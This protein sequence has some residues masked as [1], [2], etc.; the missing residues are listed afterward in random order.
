MHVMTLIRWIAL[1]S[2][3]NGY[4]IVNIHVRGVLPGRVG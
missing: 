2:L 4:I 1:H 3:L